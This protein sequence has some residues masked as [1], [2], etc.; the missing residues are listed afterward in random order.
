ME[1]AR[2][3]RTWYPLLRICISG[4]GHFLATQFVFLLGLLMLYPLVV[5][6]RATDSNGV[7]TNAKLSINQRILCRSH[8][9]TTDQFTVQR[10]VLLVRIL[11]LHIGT[12]C[13]VKH[14]LSLDGTTFVPPQQCSTQHEHQEATANCFKR[15]SH[16][17]SIPRCCCFCISH[18]FNVLS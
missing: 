6:H 5:L 7:G 8:R 2:L 10:G 9:R 4:S 17:G 3:Y 15:I 18:N 11:H 1:L 16:S 14:L 13:L 12:A